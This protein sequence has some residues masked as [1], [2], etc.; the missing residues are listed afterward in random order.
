MQSIRR[1]MDS[2]SYIEMIALRISGSK[3]G[4]LRF[5]PF[6]EPSGYFLAE[7]YK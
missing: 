5:D 1:L 2:Q 3:F 6:P 4:H 7:L